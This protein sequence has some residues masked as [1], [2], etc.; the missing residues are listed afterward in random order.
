MS[1]FRS[2]SNV[3]LP[4]TQRVIIQDMLEP[5]LLYN[6]HPQASIHYHDYTGLSVHLLLIVDYEIFP[7][8]LLI[9]SLML[10][11]VAYIAYN[12]MLRVAV[13]HN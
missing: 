4:A 9:R 11:R 3:T 5:G 12:I 6:N 1:G 7:C 2:I 13:H 10:N 8:V